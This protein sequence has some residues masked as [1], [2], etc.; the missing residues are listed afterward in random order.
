MSGALC[1]RRDWL[2]QLYFENGV[3]CL[4]RLNLRKES[5]LG[6]ELFKI[7][8]G[9]SSRR[10]VAQRIVRNELDVAC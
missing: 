8:L 10:I 7:V 5:N 3:Q 6:R 1:L 2:A 4:W 9:A